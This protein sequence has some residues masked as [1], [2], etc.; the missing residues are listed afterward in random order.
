MALDIIVTGGSG[1]LIKNLMNTHPHYNWI[2]PTSKQVNWVTGDGIDTLPK[3]SDVVI[4]A[5]ASN[6]GLVYCQNNARDIIFNNAMIN[7]RLFDWLTDH[8]HGKAIMIGSGCSYPSKVTGKFT[9]DQLGAGRM[10]SSVEAYGMSKLWALSSSEKLLHNWEQLVLA[11]MFGPHDHTSH[12]RSHLVGALTVKIMR[13]KKENT[14]VQLLGTGIAIRDI[15]Y[16]ADVVDVINN[17]INHT[18][19]NRAVNVSNGEGI[20]VRELAMLISDIA[21]YKGRILWGTD[22]DDGA[23]YKVL[24]CS[25]LDKLYPNRTRTAVRTAIEASIDYYGAA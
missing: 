22:K 24:D 13:A 19:T 5:A 9:E 2:A 16:I 25:L 8:E 17:R 10:H 11:N 20:G 3:H 21:G 23:P 18:G 6:G 15:I 4:H 12:E 7:A 14:D 1:F